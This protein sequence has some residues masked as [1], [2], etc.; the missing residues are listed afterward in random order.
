MTFSKFF[1]VLVAGILLGGFIIPNMPT[2]H[3]KVR[4]DVAG[5]Q[6]LDPAKDHIAGKLHFCP[7]LDIAVL[8]LKVRLWDGIQTFRN[9]CDKMEIWNNDVLYYV[10][11]PDYIQKLLEIPGVEGVTIQGYS[12]DIE[13]GSAFDWQEDNI[14]N[15]VKA[16]LADEFG[17]SKTSTNTTVN[18]I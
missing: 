2:H 16:V 4:A 18:K 3:T 12:I 6:S 11:P 9:R 8:D 1:L 17:K 7:N 13:K 10:D 14:L 15:R 5:E